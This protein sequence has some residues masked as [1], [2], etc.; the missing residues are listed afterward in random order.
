MWI[1]PMDEAAEPQFDDIR[2][3]ELAGI[4]GGLD[5]LDQ[6]AEAFKTCCAGT[7][8]SLSCPGCTAATFGCGGC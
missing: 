8:S 3:E 1:Q 7:A 2:D 6:D 5:G 4:V